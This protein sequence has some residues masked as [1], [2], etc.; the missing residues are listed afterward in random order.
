[1]REKMKGKPA[2]KPAEDIN[3]A[4]EQKKPEDN[5]IK[6]SNIVSATA[7]EEVKVSEPE[8]KP[9][10]EEKAPVKEQDDGER[11]SDVDAEFERKVQNNEI[12][13]PQENDLE[14]EFL[15]ERSKDFQ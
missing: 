8:I 1:M 14:E 2:Q 5:G 6:R 7:K 10:V 15:D 9:K 11:Y 13:E 4:A 12:V 3:K